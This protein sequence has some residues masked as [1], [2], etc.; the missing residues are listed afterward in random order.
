MIFEFGALGRIV[1]DERRQRFVEFVETGSRRGGTADAQPPVRTV[2]LSQQPGPGALPR[3]VVIVAETA[4]IPVTWVVPELPGAEEARA[5]IMLFEGCR[6]SDPD[7]VS[8][9]VEQAADRSILTVYAQVRTPLEELA[10]DAIAYQDLADCLDARNRHNVGGIGIGTLVGAAGTVIGGGLGSG[11]GLVGGALAGGVTNATEPIC[12]G[13]VTTEAVRRE[14]RYRNATAEVVPSWDWQV[15]SQFVEPGWDVT[16]DPPEAALRPFAYR[17]GAL[18]VPTVTATLSGPATPAD[19]DAPTRD[20]A[21]AAAPRPLAG[22][23]FRGTLGDPPLD[24]WQIVETTAPVSVVVGDDGLA[25]IDYDLTSRVVD[26]GPHR[27][28]CWRLLGNQVG[29]PVGDD[30]AFSATVPTYTLGY[31]GPDQGVDPCSRPFDPDALD[32]PVE[33]RLDAASG[34]GTIRIDL[35]DVFGADIDGALE[36]D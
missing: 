20:A 24:R 34:T 7:A 25:T 8:C 15:W 5:Q 11:I 9:R 19:S 32:L 29:V 2:A 10:G 28:G 22:S 21:P 6:S 35:P 33:G 30:G 16:E 1:N 27:P 31:A 18:T 13:L 17:E 23:T 36:R 3:S 14:V 26:G 4:T 12:G